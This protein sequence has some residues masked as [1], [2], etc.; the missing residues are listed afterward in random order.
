[1]YIEKLGGRKSTRWVP[2]KLKA[3]RSLR[4]EMTDDFGTEMGKHFWCENFMAIDNS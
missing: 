2:Q 3:W 1:M 4:L